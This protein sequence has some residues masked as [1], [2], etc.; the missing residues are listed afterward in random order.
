MAET[1]NYELHLNDDSSMTFL[2]WRKQINGLYDSNMQKLDSILWDKADK[3]FTLTTQ[4]LANQWNN[5]LQTITIDGLLQEQNGIIGL[6]PNVTIEQVNAACLSGLYIA[7]QRKDSLT[8]GY[9]GSD[10][11]V[12]IPISIILFS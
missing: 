10:P 8:I 3:S 5:K 2:E 7:E 4:L 6:S 1:N 12:D 9:K 11:T